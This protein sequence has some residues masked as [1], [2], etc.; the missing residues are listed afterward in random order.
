[1][2]KTV[3]RKE[4]IDNFFIYGLKAMQ[5]SSVALIL[6]ALASL[7]L[8]VIAVIRRSKRILLGLLFWLSFAG[9]AFI[10][11][12]T[13]IGYHYHF[14]VALP[15]FAGLCAMALRE[16]AKEWSNFSWSNNERRNAIM[17]LCLTLSVTWFSLKLYPLVR[18]WWPV[19][20]ETLMLAP[21]NEW[22][23][24]FHAP[25][26]YLNAADEIKKV[27]PKNG[28]LSVNRRSEFFYPFTGYVPPS[29]ELANLSSL[30]FKS[31]F[32][33]PHIKEALMA[34][35]PDIILM[36]SYDD[37]VSGYGNAQLFSAIHATGIYE[38]VWE[39]RFI[40]SSPDDYIR[41]V[42]FKKTKETACA[43]LGI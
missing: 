42:I 41:V 21:D 34:C 24:V 29:N 39:L 8:I 25:G 26:S 35:A 38:K 5:L 20:L 9:L 37:W 17:L 14:A 6:S 15:G 3:P 4:I 11:P 23:E 19:T 40:N 13:Q 18:Y 12:A 32:S 28:T 1:M 2:Y 27:I 36:N 7:V 22:P 31:G 43:S 10:E 30:G 16:A 33:V